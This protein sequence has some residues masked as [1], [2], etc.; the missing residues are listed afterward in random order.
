[1]ALLLSA[2]GCVVINSMIDGFNASRM[3]CPERRSR[4]ENIYFPIAWNRA[5]SLTHR[6][7]PSGSSC[8]SL[9][10]FQHRRPEGDLKKEVVA[11]GSELDGVFIYTCSKHSLRID[12]GHCARH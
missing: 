12:A 9:W 8:L 10:Q 11:G 3:G 7:Y 4:T 1:M 5:V 6:V 2:S